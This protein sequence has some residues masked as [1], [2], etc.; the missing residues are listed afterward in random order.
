MQQE[1]NDLHNGPADAT[2]T[3]LSLASLISRMVSPFWCRLTE[4]VLE[5]RPLNGC[6]FISIYQLYLSI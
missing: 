1:A 3:P 2:A 5:K 6:L 4:V